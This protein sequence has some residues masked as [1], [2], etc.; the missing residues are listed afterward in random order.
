MN[1]D[2]LIEKEEIRD[3]INDAIKKLP[4]KE[5]ICSER[6]KNILWN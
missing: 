1:P 3:Y 4:E 5:R 2:V 6:K